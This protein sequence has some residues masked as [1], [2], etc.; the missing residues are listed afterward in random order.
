M[1]SSVVRC[2][3]RGRVQLLRV[4]AHKR[5]HEIRAGV[6]GQRDLASASLLHDAAHVASLG[7]KQAGGAVPEAVEAAGRWL[8][9]PAMRGRRPAWLLFAGSAAGTGLLWQLTTAR[10]CDGCG[11]SKAAETDTRRPGAATGVRLAACP[12]PGPYRFTEGPGVRRSASRW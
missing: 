7:K 12:P 3:A 9:G 1:L 11:P 5:R 10:G 4:V 2:I 6:S 8:R